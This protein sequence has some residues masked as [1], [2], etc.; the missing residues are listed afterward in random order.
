M[1]SGQTPA[2]W[3][4]QADTFDDE[5]DHGLQDPATRDAWRQLLD[6]VLPEAPSRVADLG[7][8]TG[9]LAVLLAENGHQVDGIDF[10]PE[11]VNRARAKAAEHGVAASFEIGD[12]SAPTLP[13]RTYD[14]VLSRHVLWAMKDPVETV[15]R[16]CDLLSPGGILVL[17]EG[18]WSTGAGLHASEASQAVRVHRMQAKVTPLTDP[19]L[20][21]KETTDERYLLVSTR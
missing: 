3:D 5:A 2:L 8:G 1:S 13:R 16:W 11:M 17:V 19:V 21:G 10:A 20:W 15:A 7:C 14:V 9:S 4:A 6:G 12:A 18:F